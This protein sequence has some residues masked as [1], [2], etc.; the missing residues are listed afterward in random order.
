MAEMPKGRKEAIEKARDLLSEYFD[1]GL[2]IVSWEEEGTTYNMTLRFGNFYAVESL[3]D[4][5]GDILDLNDGEEE[6]EA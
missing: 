1:C 6:V 2:A 4:Q 3:A 5:A